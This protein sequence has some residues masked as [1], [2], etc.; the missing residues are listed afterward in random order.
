MKRKTV[1][2]LIALS[3]TM[4][5][6]ACGSEASVDAETN[7]EGNIS[8]AEASAKEDDTAADNT[9]AEATGESTGGNYISPL[10]VTVDL[11]NPEDMVAPVKFIKDGFNTESGELTFTMYSI[12]RYDSVQIS[13]LQIGDI[14][15]YDGAD[16]KVE[17]IEDVNGSL[18]I[19][20][21]L[22]LGGCDLKPND[23]GT[24]V[25]Q[26][27]DDYP[28]YTEIGVLTLPLSEALIFSDAIDDPNN[29]RQVNKEGL[30]DYLEGLDESDGK[31]FFPGNTTLEIR[32]SQ[33][34]NITRRWV[35]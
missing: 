26:G 3:L 28:T 10:P 27:M 31:Y 22:E 15:K 23:G 2:I 8:T 14:L 20:G 13:M 17:S 4:L 33:I 12:D 7:P 34:I 18:V 9:E 11:S 32:N 24:Y 19:N 16:I 30:A 21:G 6:T 25:G 1:S 35:P 5:L 29:P